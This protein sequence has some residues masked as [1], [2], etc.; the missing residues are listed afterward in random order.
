MQKT[1]GLIGG[2]S[3]ESTAVYYRQINEIVREQRGGLH[4]ADILLASVDFQTIV[5]WQTS[6]QWDRAAEYLAGVANRLEQA[7]ADCLVIC[8][9]TMHRI[10]A[11]IAQAV[12]IPLIHIVDVTGAALRAGGARKPLLLAT[13]YTME[14]TFYRDRLHQ[15]FGLDAT[16]PDAAGRE[17]V[18]RVIFEELCC[19]IVSAA[20]RQAFQDLIAAARHKGCDSVILGC[21]EIGLLIGPEDCALPAYDSTLLH[22]AAAVDFALADTRAAARRVA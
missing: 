16:V 6:G 2:M 18:H 13:R 22:A 8:T 10:A 9:N 15:I 4:S 1:I 7:G 20:S 3:W 14:D 21:T 19:G 12:A 11:P 5:D 17:L